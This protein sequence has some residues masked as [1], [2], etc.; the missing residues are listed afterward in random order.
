[1]KVQAILDL[2][3]DYPNTN[4]ELVI[5]IYLQKRNLQMSTV[6]IQRY[7]NNFSLFAVVFTTSQQTVTL[8]SK[9][10]KKTSSP[11]NFGSV[12][13]EYVS[14]KTGKYRIQNKLLQSSYAF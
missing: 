12:K 13:N 6:C 9:I 10:F 3:R 8:N 11:N 1:M 14:V 5:L 4:Q 2:T 7:V